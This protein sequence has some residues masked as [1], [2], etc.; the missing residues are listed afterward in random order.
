MIVESTARP[1]R[2]FRMTI[3][4]DEMP[5]TSGHVDCRHI[6]TRCR[7]LGRKPCVPGSIGGFLAHGGGVRR[8]EVILESLS[9]MPE[10][11]HHSMGGCI[12]AYHRGI[13]FLDMF[14][15]MTEVVGALSALGFWGFRAI[16][17]AEAGSDGSVARPLVS[18]FSTSV[19]VFARLTTHVAGRLGD[20]V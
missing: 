15:C 13:A 6:Q 9:G 4:D 11:A 12:D 10:V 17:A 2:L 5:L 3:S 14:R 18:S 7:G 8:L 20:G 16:L 1:T 19:S